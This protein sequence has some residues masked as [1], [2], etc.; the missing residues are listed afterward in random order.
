MRY[1]ALLDS[2]TAELGG[3][4]ADEFQRAIKSTQ[5]VAA[6]ELL[7]HHFGLVCQALAFVPSDAEARRVLGYA[8]KAIARKRCEAERLVG[9]MKRAW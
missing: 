6:P 3:R 5:Q 1:R 7:A 8:S 9:A 2:Y 4:L